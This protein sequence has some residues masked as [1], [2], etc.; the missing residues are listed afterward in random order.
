L[1]RPE[2]HAANP[3]A[4]VVQDADK[5]VRMR[6]WENRS[7]EYRTVGHAAGLSARRWNRLGDR[8]NHKMRIDNFHAQ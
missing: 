2:G 6:E 1:T 3:E 7:T 8:E 5:P 4:P